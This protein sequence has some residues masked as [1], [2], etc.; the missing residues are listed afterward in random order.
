MVALRRDTTGVS[1]GCCEQ[2]VVRDLQKLGQAKNVMEGRALYATE[3]P[4]LDRSGA[5]FEEIAE[6]RPGV[7]STFAPLVE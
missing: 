2:V 6:L 4:A 1:R 5:D 7:P 3:L